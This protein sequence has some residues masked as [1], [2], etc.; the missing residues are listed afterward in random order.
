MKITVQIERPESGSG[1]SQQGADRLT[2][3]DFPT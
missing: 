3:T 1:K 2:L